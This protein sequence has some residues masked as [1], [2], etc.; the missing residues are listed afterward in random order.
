MMNKKMG[1]P[2]AK[3][4]ETYVYKT[5]QNIGGMNQTTAISDIYKTVSSLIP[6]KQFNSVCTLPNSDAGMMSAC[7]ILSKTTHDVYDEITS[8]KTIDLSVMPIIYETSQY[9]ATTITQYI[10]THG[11]DNVNI[12]H[13]SI[14][15]KALAVTTT[16]QG[17]TKYFPVRNSS[18]I[19]RAR[20]IRT[21]NSASVF[22]RVIVS[23]ETSVIIYLL[24]QP[25]KTPSFIYNFGARNNFSNYTFDIT[26]NLPTPPSADF[27]LHGLVIF[28]DMFCLLISMGLTPI[29]AMF[30]WTQPQPENITLK[31]S[32]D[33][34]TNYML[35]VGSSSDNLVRDV[36]YGTD[37]LAYA[38]LDQPP[39]TS[40]L[41]SVV[42]VNP[43]TPKV[44][45]VVKSDTGVDNNVKFITCFVSA[46]HLIVTITGPNRNPQVDMFDIVQNTNIRLLDL[47]KIDDVVFSSASSRKSDQQIQI[48]IVAHNITKNTF[49][50]HFGFAAY[51]SAAS[52]ALSQLKF[53][54]KVVATNI[55]TVCEGGKY[56]ISTSDKLVIL[57]DDLLA[58]PSIWPVSIY[59][60]VAAGN[61]YFSDTTYDN[62]D[63]TMWWNGATEQK[64]P[65][66]QFDVSGISPHNRMRYTMRADLNTNYLDHDLKCELLNS[67]HLLVQHGVSISNQGRIRST[68]SIDK[69]VVD[70][71]FEDG[72]YFDKDTVAST[73][74]VVNVDQ[75]FTSPN[76]VYVGQWKNNVLRVYR[77]IFNTTLFADWLEKAPSQVY[78]QALVAMSQLCSDH[79]R[80]GPDSTSMSDKFCFCPPNMNLLDT[81]FK[82]NEIT[83][84]EKNALNL[85]MPCLTR[86]CNVATIDQRKTLSSLIKTKTCTSPITVCSNIVKNKDMIVDTVIIKPECGTSIGCRNQPTLCVIGEK[87]VDDRCVKTCEK[88]TECMTG[89]VCT[90]N[91]CVKPTSTS[92]NSGLSGGAIAGIV[93]GVIVLLIIVITLSVVYGRKKK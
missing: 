16:D 93:I 39:S 25:Q 65:P 85:K 10:P 26:K 29:V 81:I 31:N 64:W 12:K 55:K 6:S 82:T 50:L 7:D 80:N 21:R 27:T 89:F 57:G 48:L 73:R 83:P 56:G 8:G 34:L 46:K 90:N 59:D 51:D 58:S 67:V 42:I 20:M 52:T 74:L 86:N 28:D 38:V 79:L 40:K 3:A 88:N 71:K 19:D 47:P 69:P 63:K 44:L 22:E 1:D 78:D 17:G 84:Q 14:G 18:Q 43:L 72:F 61:F 45:R 9:S 62:D 41:F 53:D 92:K 5:P 76:G 37:L 70:S 32:T 60:P 23:D 2:V 49:A 68:E 13:V 35:P 54:W 11:P 4:F 15:K 75:T 30:L 77:N 66:P 87:C 36:L 91:V 24:V 33:Y